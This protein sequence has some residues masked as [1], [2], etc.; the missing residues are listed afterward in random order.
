MAGSVESP[1]Y[2]N[3]EREA[4]GLLVRLVAVHLKIE[5]HLFLDLQAR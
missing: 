2:R 3:A 4:E 1:D 5:V